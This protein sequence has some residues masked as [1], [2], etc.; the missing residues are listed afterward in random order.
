MT[1]WIENDYLDPVVWREIL[2]KR[3]TI[4]DLIDRLYE[5]AQSVD[6]KLHE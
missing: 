5:S 1:C 2:A 3:E 4:L 6:I